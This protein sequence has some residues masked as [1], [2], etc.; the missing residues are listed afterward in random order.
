MTSINAVS[1]PSRFLSLFSKARILHIWLL[2]TIIGLLMT[3]VSVLY[4]EI[5]GS[6]KYWFHL[7]FT[8][9]SS[10]WAWAALTPFIYK[11]YKRYDLLNARLID[12][13]KIFLASALV[14]AV[15]HRFLAYCINYLI[16]YSYGF[17]SEGFIDTMLRWKGFLVYSGLIDIA[18]YGVILLVLFL[19][20]YR[21]KL[22]LKP[23]TSQDLEIDQATPIERLAIKD[24][25]SVFF[26]MVHEI[27]LVKAEGN[28]LKIATH[29][30]SYLHRETLKSLQR[31]LDPSVF[32]RLNRSVL[33]NINEIK[34]LQTWFNGEY[35]VLLKD[36]SKLNTS[37]VYREELN[38][39]LNIK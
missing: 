31:R 4:Y 23:Q 13:L 17:N 30:Q 39:L 20:D 15:V 11:F 16:R 7:S 8:K 3:A 14:A 37:R 18:I 35:R 1:I 24:N 34:E 10:M 5:L 32:F 38:R 33:V 12:I 25:G 28:Y 26:V 22:T 36:G 6:P 19:I 9:I 2:W 27:K 21:T 29:G